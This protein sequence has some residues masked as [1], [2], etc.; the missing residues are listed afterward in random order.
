MQR[1]RFTGLWQNPDFM[2]LWV[3]QTISVFGSM[4]GGT[5]MAFTA[6]LVLKATPFQ[7]GAL[8]AARMLPG[9]L[10]GLVAGVWVD[11]LRR[12]PILIGADLGRALVLASVPAAA[13]VGLLHIE[14]LYIVAF[15]VSMLTIFFDVA[16]RTYLPSLV[17]RDELLE[18]NS[19]LSASASVAEFGGVS[20]AGWLVQILAAPIAVL[21]DAISF[22]ISA[23]SVWLIRAPEKVEVREAEPDMRREIAEGLHAILRHPVLRAIATCSLSESFFQGIYEAL[24]VLYMARN[25]GFQPGILASI[26]ALGGISSF[27]GALAAGPVTRRMGIGPAMI[28]GLLLSTISAFFI[29]LA[30]GATLMAALLLIL[31]QCGDGAATIYQINQVSLNQAIAPGQV[32]GRVNA[33]MKFVALGATLAG[34]V[35]GGLLGSTMGVREAL[36]LAAFGG[37]LSTLWLVFSPVRNLRDALPVEAEAEA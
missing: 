9:F 29:P 25:L 20:L 8:A 10:I 3:G 17:R 24:V 32:L 16:Y 27:F 11:R 33:G 15:V 34:A 26:W 1:Q 14:Q 36:F 28:F 4:I 18:G 6:I 13:I 35:V 19:K 21:I 5:A 22:A 23:V 12:R 2:R 31:A 30:E 37:I 7:L